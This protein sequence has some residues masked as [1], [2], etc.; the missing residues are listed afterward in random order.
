MMKCLNLN[1]E[2]GLENF[3]EFWHNQVLICKSLLRSLQ[4]PADVKEKGIR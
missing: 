3:I 4:C 2:M 1:Q